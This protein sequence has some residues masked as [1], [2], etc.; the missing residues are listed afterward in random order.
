[1]RKIE[2][3]S[4]QYFLEHHSLIP[5]RAVQDLFYLPQS[6]LSTPATAQDGEAE[7]APP[8]KRRATGDVSPSHC[9]SPET[10]AKAE[11]KVTPMETDEIIQIFSIPPE[12]Y[13]L[14]ISDVAGEL[15]RVATNA[16]GGGDVTGGVVTVVLST[17]R[18]LYETLEGFFGRLASRSGRELKKKQSVTQ[19]SIRKIEN[20]LYG[21]KVRAEEYADADVA[22]LQEMVRRS[23]AQAE[24]P[25][26]EE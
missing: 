23:L 16:V 25:P 21:V 5:Y 13:L 26:E 12:R 15:M 18:E 14:G 3:L 17:L 9:P 24:A 4:L 1:M 8:P 6:V 20:V 11:V 10:I 7:L 19:E 2:A 22:L